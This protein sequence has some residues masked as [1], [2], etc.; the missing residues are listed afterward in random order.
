MRP[1]IA[2]DT[3]AAFAA[4][5]LAAVNFPRLFDF[6]M[7]PRAVAHERHKVFAVAVRVAAA[8]LVATVG[9][10]AFRRVFEAGPVTPWTVGPIELCA[11]IAARANGG[12]RGFIAQDFAIIATPGASEHVF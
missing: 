4:S 10:L 5:V 11:A 6:R 3:P 9:I 8:T 12:I 2:D 1:E 7:T